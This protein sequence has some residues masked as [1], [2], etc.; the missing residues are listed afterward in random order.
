MDDVGKVREKIDLV[1][2]ISEYIT[3]KK[4]G[5]NFKA[6]CPFHNEK[7]P[8]FMVSPERQIWHC[9]GCGKG[10]DSFTF[11]MEYEN[12]EFPE[13]LRALAKKAGVELNESSYRKG[14][15]SEKEK[16]FEINKLALKFYKYLLLEHKVGKTALEYLTQKR[17]LKKGTIE[18]FE[19]GFAPSSASSLCE[20]LM[21]KKSFKPR[22]LTSAGIAFEKAGKV[23]DFFRGRII[24]PLYDHR[25]NIL[26]FSGRALNE[27]EM[28]KYINTRET[29]VYQKG[30][31][32]FGLNLSKEEIKEKQNA[33]LVEGEF[34]LISLFTFGIKN[35]VA[36]KG[37]ALT[38]AQVALIARFSPKV[39][40]CF[41]NDNAGFEATKRSLA[42]VESRGL[43]ASVVNLGKA[44]DPDDA[45]T[46]D[47]ISFK[48]SLNNAPNAYD[49]FL[50][51]YLR[52]NTK[53]TVEGKKKISTDFLPLV[54]T[55]SNEIVKEHYTKKLAS[56]LDISSES[57]SA[58]L[59]KLQSKK[60]EDKIIVPQR[61]VKERRELLEEYLLSM[62]VQSE[63]MED[64]L[65][66][67]KQ[68]LLNYKFKI[69]SYQKILEALFDFSKE[70]NGDIKKFSNYISSEL[71]PAFDFLYLYPLPKFTSEEKAN[72][73]IA[74]VIKEL[75]SIHLREKLK[76]ISQK[77]KSSKLESKDQLQKE[78]TQIL[79]LIKQ[80][81][82]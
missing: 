53:D 68:D 35:V 13:S 44:K 2:L 37:T 33:I 77:L 16:I 75:V 15:S 65:S 73:E 17:G 9:F 50:D 66:E 34:D 82:V 58:E 25:G 41:D 36:I 31:V 54:S 4:A 10:G 19:I 70:K 47:E 39:T 64:L 42:A 26:G 8:S 5:R 71:L 57:V 21:K 61:E 27:T 23:Y 49:F 74:K 43:T 81:R 6:V 24:F 55:I 45:I 18:T 3:L 48:K 63:K 38:E 46:N 1:S 7:S 80:R 78:Y 14:V 72:E 62:I 40:F 67:N 29:L 60:T 79:S 69:P 76:E 52:E 12:M 30:S 51:Y 28:P 59:E 11:L 20:Y 22:D 32:F 56:S